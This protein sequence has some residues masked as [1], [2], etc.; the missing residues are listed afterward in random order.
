MGR[1]VLADDSDFQEL[2][3]WFPGGACEGVSS[4]I[5]VDVRRVSDSCGYG[6]PLMTFEGHR[7]TMDQ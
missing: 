5:V 6:V 2:A 3:G 4:V 1:A 7:P